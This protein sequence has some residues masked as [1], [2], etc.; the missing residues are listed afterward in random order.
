MNFD[1]A[2]LLRA[3]KAVG[4]VLAALPA[5]RALFDQAAAALSDDDQATAKEALADLIA[6]NDDGHRRL[7]EKLD[8]AA[9]R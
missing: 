4:P 9:Q 1:L 6:D 2:T 8:A 7:Q 5:V 3:A